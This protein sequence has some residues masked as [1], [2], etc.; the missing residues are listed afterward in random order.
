MVIKME[1]NNFNQNQANS[2]NQEPIYQN[3][4]GLEKKEN[5]N[6][7]LIFALVIALIALIVM[8]YLYTDVNNEY[9]ELKHVSL[10]RKIYA[11]GALEAAR[12]IMCKEKGLFS[13]SDCIFY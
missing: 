4:Q 2:V 12:W 7:A 9:I 10:S 1:E 5:S 6:K 3:N 13:Y 8:A 11:L